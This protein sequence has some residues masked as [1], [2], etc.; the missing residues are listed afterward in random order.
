MAV[1]L[2]PQELNLDWFLTLEE[3]LDYHG[4]YFGMPRKDRR[5]RDDGAARDVLADATRRTTARA[6]CRAA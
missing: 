3:T 5:E 6:R 1:G 4:G 2:A